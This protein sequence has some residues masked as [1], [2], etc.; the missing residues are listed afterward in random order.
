MINLKVFSNLAEALELYGQLG[1]KLEPDMAKAMNRA[2]HG[3]R[4]DEVKLRPLGTG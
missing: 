4:T 3:V 1:D 2:G